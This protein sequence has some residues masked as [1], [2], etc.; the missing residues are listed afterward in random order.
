MRG[1]R[2]DRLLGIHYVTWIFTVGMATVALLAQI[3]DVDWD[4]HTI[5]FYGWPVK[6]YDSP[7]G[8]AL[9]DGDFF[10]GVEADNPAPSSMAMALNIVFYVVLV[11]AVA[12]VCEQLACEWRKPS[13]I[14]LAALLWVSSVTAGTLA[15]VNQDYWPI[16][17]KVFRFLHVSPQDADGI[18]WYLSLPSYFGIACT[19]YWVSDS[20]LRR[21][22]TLLQK[23]RTAQLVS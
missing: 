9:S 4:N 17:Y 13:Q 14:S 23:S 7:L 21:C 15:I 19:I 5:W 16:A 6:L 1:L 11:R 12:Y 8:I 18:V 10:V 3:E 20:V 22:R 2:N